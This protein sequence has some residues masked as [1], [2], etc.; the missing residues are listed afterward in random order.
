MLIVEAGGLGRPFKPCV[1]VLASSAA[2]AALAAAFARRFCFFRFT[3][4]AE[5][6]SMAAL[7]A[8]V[9]AEESSF[10]EVIVVGDGWAGGVEA[11]DFGIVMLLVPSLFV[12]FAVGAFA[13]D[14]VGVATA[15]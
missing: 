7:G 12:Y 10:G 3:V 14:A 13:A 5:L 1:V 6:S 11:E 4:G 8:T 2:A 15:C 9:F